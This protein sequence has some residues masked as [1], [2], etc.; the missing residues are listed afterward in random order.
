MGG[1]GLEGPQKDYVILECSLTFW[2]SF[3][4]YYFYTD[5]SESKSRVA[6]GLRCA[7]RRIRKPRKFVYKVFYSFETETVSFNYYII[8]III[9]IN[10]S[11][12]YLWFSC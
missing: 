7:K 2:S 8:T 3:G 1:G 4:L 12:S 11:L 10:G 5:Q 9:I 6:D